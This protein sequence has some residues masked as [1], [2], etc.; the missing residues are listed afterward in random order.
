M[1]KM[2]IHRAL[3]E[4]KMIDARIEK[5]ILAIEPTGVTQKD[6]LVNQFY[7]R[8]DFEKEAKSKLQSVNDL[9]ERKNKIKSAIVKANSVTLVEINGNKMTIADAINFKHVIEFKKKLISTL[10]H[11]HRNAKATVERNNKQ[12]TDNALKLAEAALQK[13]NVKIGDNDAV[14][15]TE[16]YLDKNQYH[17]VD[18]LDVDKLVETLQI[19]VSNFECEVDAVLSEINAITN[20]EI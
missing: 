18:P 7:K 8:E 11:K 12:V 10:E 16:P 20:I 1:D 13:D 6:K 14:A 9:I 5:A 2:S 3:S 19:E 17:I 15:I 4:L